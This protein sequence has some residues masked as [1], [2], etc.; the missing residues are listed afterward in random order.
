ME[1]PTKKT[2]WKDSRTGGKYIFLAYR[3]L[4]PQEAADQMAN[5]LTNSK[6]PRATKTHSIV[7]ETLIG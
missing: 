1:R 4:T 7:I 2:T 6:N 3:I 5:Y